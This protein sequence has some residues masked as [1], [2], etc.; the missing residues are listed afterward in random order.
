MVIDG[1]ARTATAALA[2]RGHSFALLGSGDQ[3]GQIAAWARVLSSL[4]REGSKSIVSSGSS[5]AFPMTE[6]RSANT[7]SIMPCSVLIRPPG[8]PIR[9]WLTNPRR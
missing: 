3:D 7:L 6:E 1:R 9:R 8:A 2:V 4:A 5:R